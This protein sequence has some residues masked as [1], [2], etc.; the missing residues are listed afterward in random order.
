MLAQSTKTGLRVDLNTDDLAVNGYSV[1]LQY[2]AAAFR[3]LEVEDE[4]SALR[5]DG[6]EALRI[7][8][9]TPGE[10][11]ILGG[12]TGSPET[13]EGLL[14]SLHFEPV[15]LEAEGAFRILDG[16]VQLENSVVRPVE[17]AEIE[18]RFTPQVFALHGNYPN[19]SIH[20][21]QSGI[22]CL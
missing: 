1:V 15:T 18:A 20:P 19:R 21:P 7:V 10:L 11:L 13:V 16:A 3:F 2:D 17:L 6:R 9:E 5:S 8:R 4:S 22:S 14:A 12:R